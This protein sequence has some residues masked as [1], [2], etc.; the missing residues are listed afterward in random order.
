MTTEIRIVLAE[1]HAVVRSALRLLLDAEADMTVVGEA[2][3]GLEAV[4]RAS[5]LQPDVILMDIAMPGLGGIE[6]ARQV[7]RHCPQVNVLILTMYDDPE[8]FFRSLEAGA[9]GYVPKSASE[10]E[11][12]RA[13]RTV[14]RGQSY[15]YPS[16]AT[17]LVSDYLE[18]VRQGERSD[19]YERLTERERETLSLIAAGFSNREIADRL[20]IS[21]HTVHNH[22]ARLMEK[23]G[24]HDRLE[25]LKYAIRRGLVDV[26]P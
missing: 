17:A 15:L 9:L 6:A 7:V 3:N 11:L 2:E 23:L 5:H 18:L 4:A 21:V 26:E 8:H 19:P 12:L 14:A 1:D 16:L 13:V 22:R 20:C 10:Q 25:L 24:L